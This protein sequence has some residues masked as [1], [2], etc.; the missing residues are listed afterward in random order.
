MQQLQHLL[1]PIK[2]KK[3]GVGKLTI[4]QRRCVHTACCMWY[5]HEGSTINLASHAKKRV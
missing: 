2:L 1:L 5:G 3:I 4:I